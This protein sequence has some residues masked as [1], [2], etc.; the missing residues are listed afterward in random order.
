MKF[1]NTAAANNFQQVEKID[2]HVWIR[3]E[4]LDGILQNF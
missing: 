3:F 4:V 2:F 1:I